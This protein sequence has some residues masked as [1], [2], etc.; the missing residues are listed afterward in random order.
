M[1]S[2]TCHIREEKGI[3]FY[4]SQK[5]LLSSA[6]KMIDDSGNFKVKEKIKLHYAKGKLY[7]E[8]IIYGEP[9]FTDAVL[10]AEA[11]DYITA[12]LS[13]EEVD[14]MEIIKQIQNGNLKTS[15]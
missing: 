12:D 15:F 2:S 14:P 8:G 3:R 13:S 7:T 10:V 4:F 6:Q 5:Q 1:D 11:V 9:Q